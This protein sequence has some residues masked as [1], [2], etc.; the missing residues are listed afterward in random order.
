MSKLDIKS[1]F[2][3]IPVHPSDWELLGMKWEG[4]YFFDM[5]L[6]FGLRSAP[7]LFDQFSSALEWIIQTKLQIPKVIH[8]LDDFF[9]TTLPPWAQCMTSLCQILLLFTDL[10]IP[11]APGKT[12]P[13]STS[14]KF[15]GVL[16]DSNAMEAWLP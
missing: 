16:L 6:P 8:I 11:L 2:C 1:A 15:M 3:N 5:T 4:L 9:F 12:F 10:N 13:A 14:L 7:F